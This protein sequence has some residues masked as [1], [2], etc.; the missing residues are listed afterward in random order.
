MRGHCIFPAMPR[1]T[2][3]GEAASS[4]AVVMA[5]HALTAIAVGLYIL[6]LVACVRAAFRRGTPRRAGYFWLMIA[7]AMFMLAVCKALGLPE[8]VTELGR[9]LAQSE[10]WYA[11]RRPLQAAGIGALVIVCTLAGLAGA[12]VVRR[13]GRRGLPAL[14]ATSVLLVYVAAQ[15]ISLHQLD[16]A[17]A[18]AHAGR[19]V[20][21]AAILVVAI[22]AWRFRGE[23]S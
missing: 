10:G 18:L 6:A 15:A 8:L 14:I 5:H 3:A 17:L 11:R 19:A 13:V 7:S 20:E 4:L 1:P 21:A 2:F 23:V 22:C 9:D 12:R 16:H